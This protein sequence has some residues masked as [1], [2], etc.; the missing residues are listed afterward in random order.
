MKNNRSRGARS[1]D[2]LLL[3]GILL[4]GSAVQLLYAGEFSYNLE[5]TGTR[6]DNITRV[7]IN[8]RKETV[9]SLLAGFAYVEDTRDLV[10]RVLAQAEY[11]DYLKDVYDDETVFNLN[12]SLVWT[13]SPQRFQWTLED[14]HRQD[15]VDSTVVDTPSNRTNINVLSTGPDVYLRFAPLHVLALGARVGNVYTGSANLDNNRFNGSAG[16]LYQSSSVTTYSINYEILDVKYKDSTLND[17]FRRQDV[18]F[19]TQ[20]RPSRSQ[21]E[22]DL[23]TTEISRDRGNDLSDTLAKF[24]WL[25]QLT[26]E[27]TFGVSAKREFSDTATD[28]LTASTALTSG[29]ITAPPTLSRSVL[30]SDV[31]YAKRTEMFYTY[32]GNQVGVQFQAGRHNLDFELTNQDREENGGRLRIEYFYSGATTLSLF[33]EYTSTEYLNFVQRDRDNNSGVHLEYR[34]NRAISLGVEGRRNERS[35]SVAT[36]NYVENQALFSVMY[37]SGSLFTPVSER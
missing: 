8:E 12:S 15:L 6:S 18:F 5:Y 26:P 16:W 4:S 11:R 9:H 1:R 34:L 2:K 36:N 35:S 10:A 32:R 27:S 13:I 17:D 24:S 37:R 21:Y 31:Y 20:F 14:S 19:R 23:G 28:I 29:Q 30:T 3:T 22:L 7:P 33:T 25:R